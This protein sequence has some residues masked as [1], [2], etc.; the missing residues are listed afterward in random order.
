MDY[1]VVLKD[2]VFQK[3]ICDEEYCDFYKCPY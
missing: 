3:L 2:P 1:T